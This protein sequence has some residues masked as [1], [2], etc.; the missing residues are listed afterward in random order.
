M[1]NKEKG[2]AKKAENGEKDVGKD[3]GTKIQN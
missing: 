2:P 1:R 3:A